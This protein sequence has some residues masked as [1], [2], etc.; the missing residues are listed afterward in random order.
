MDLLRTSRPIQTVPEVVTLEALVR[1]DHLLRKI[2][3]AID[4]SF[5]P[6]PIHSVDVTLPQ[7]SELPAP[8]GDVNHVTIDTADVI[9]WNDEAV[10]IAEW[11]FLVKAGAE[12]PEAAPLMLAPEAHA[13]YLR[14]DEAIGAIRRSGGTRIAFPCLQQYD[15]L[16]QD[17][18]G[19]CLIR[20][21][22]SADVLK[23]APDQAGSIIRRWAPYR[24]ADAASCSSHNRP[25]RAVRPC[26]A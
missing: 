9:R 23:A 20:Q 10:D 15:G 2:E 24:A 16:I 21:H 8:A 22:P 4:I 5:I 18:K 3:A 6:P 1:K 26:G 19:R 12:R 14:V 17:R 25:F 7:G 11:G 13:R